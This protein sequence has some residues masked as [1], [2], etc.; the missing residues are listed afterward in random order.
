MC[1][2]LC[3][4]LPGRYVSA[5]A[6]SQ[7]LVFLFAVATSFGSARAQMITPDDARDGARFA[8][9]ARAVERAGFSAPV[10]VGKGRDAFDGLFALLSSRAGKGVLLVVR[11]P[12]RGASP[13]PIVLETDKSPADIGVDSVRIAS[14]L[15]EGGLMD[16]TVGHRPFQL[17]MS[18]TY[19]RHHLLRGDGGRLFPAGEFDGDSSWGYAK[20]PRSV[21]ETVTVTISRP[22]G[23][24]SLSF[25]VRSVRVKT[26][27]SAPNA[28]PAVER[29]EEVTRF[30][31]DA[32]GRF[33][34]VKK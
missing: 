9:A 25:D 1:D 20:G 6:R 8:A 17:E 29:R 7:A 26:E 33:S 18:R 15:G 4:F 13:S 22:P 30:E 10:V 21:T 3:R 27:K 23:D 16:V 31:P 24:G 2:A 11:E 28:P 14:F 19:D 5:A 12:S 32:A 34:P